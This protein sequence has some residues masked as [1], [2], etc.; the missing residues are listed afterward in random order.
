MGL[1]IEGWAALP[2]RYL[3]GVRYRG[4]EVSPLAGTLGSR[5]RMVAIHVADSAQSSAFAGQAI[6]TSMS[7]IFVAIIV[8]CTSLP[9]TTEPTEQSQSY[10]MSQ[11]TLGC[12]P[13]GHSEMSGVFALVVP[14]RPASHRTSIASCSFN[15]QFFGALTI[16]LRGALGRAM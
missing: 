4:R 10:E 1:S 8:S 7:S 12:V 6:A 15:G 14:V 16:P 13:S 2:F 9:A 11:V 5:H 3:V